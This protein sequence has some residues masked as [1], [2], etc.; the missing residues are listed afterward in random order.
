M[1]WI[2]G[3]DDRNDDNKDAYVDHNDNVEDAVTK[4]VIISKILNA[5]MVTEIAT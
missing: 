4:V 5:W 1:L 3:N 2:S